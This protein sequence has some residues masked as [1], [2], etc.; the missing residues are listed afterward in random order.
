ML[1]KVQQVYKEFVSTEE[2]LHQCL[3]GFGSKR[4]CVCVRA[5]VHVKA[6][7]CYYV[8]SYRLCYGS[9]LEQTLKEGPLPL[10]PLHA[11]WGIGLGDD[12]KMS[13]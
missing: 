13:L 12:G 9:V 10:A 2:K 4:D 1:Y 3:G 8:P 6:L 11:L 5:C 7:F